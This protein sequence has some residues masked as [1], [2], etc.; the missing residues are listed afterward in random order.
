MANVN[1][2]AANIAKIRLAEQGSDPAAPASGFAY[3]FVKSDG[4]AYLGNDGSSILPLVLTLVS[5]TSSL[6]VGAKVLSFEDGLAIGIT[7]TTAYIK[8]Q[9]SVGQGGWI[10][11]EETW[12]YA[13]ADAPTFT[14]T[15]SGDKTGKYSAGMRVRL[16]QATGGTKY[17]I[18]TVVAHAAGT[19]TITVYG[20]TDYVLANQ[21][22]NNPNYSRDKAPIG[23]PLDPSKWKVRVISTDASSQ[24]TPTQNQWYN[25]GSVTISIPIG[26]WD[27]SYS[28]SAYAIDAAL[29]NINI[30]STL[31]TANN[32]ESDVDFSCVS[33]ETSVAAA[34]TTLIAH[35][36]RAKTL[37]LAAKT[38]Y[39]VNG[40]TSVAGVDTIAH[41]V[42]SPP[43]IVEAVCVYL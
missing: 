26:I 29:A 30:F 39:Y 19:T 38:S 31:S 22:I 2:G 8:S 27:V 23:F 17:F 40:K 34:S 11:V 15:I 33:S 42:S 10:G 41:Y 1:I 16:V 36:A 32:S 6:L 12:T 13:S 18:I 25:L 37:V 7:G 5:G 14:F 20:G 35:H 43:T 21:A 24:S 4:Q 28:T 9:D 3:L